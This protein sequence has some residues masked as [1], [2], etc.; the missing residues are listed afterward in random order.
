MTDQ[1]AFKLEV[2]APVFPVT[3]MSKSL[4]FYT[5]QLLFKVG[6]E[7]SDNDQEPPRYSI[8]QQ[9]NT[10]LHLTLTTEARATVAYFFVDNVEGY[11][12]A[13]KAKGA[14]ITEEITDYPWDM[15]EFE[16]T[17]PDGNRVI[18]GEHLSRLKGKES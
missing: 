17:D 7:W 6:F 18:F 4:R 3:D 16:V 12:E 9:G 2:V 8:L 15:R 5:D 10:E 11:Y 13:V 1:T 14:N